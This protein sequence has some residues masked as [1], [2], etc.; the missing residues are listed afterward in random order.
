MNM[1]TASILLGLS[2]TIFL[3]WLWDKQHIEN[4]RDNR[5]S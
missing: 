5:E 2:Y 1:M 4:E 3:I